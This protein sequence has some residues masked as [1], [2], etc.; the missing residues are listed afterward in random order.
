[1]DPCPARCQRDAPGRVVAAPLGAHP[2]L[3]RLLQ[4]TGDVMKTLSERGFDGAKN[5]AN[6]E[7]PPR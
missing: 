4:A 7:T 1:M 5:P 2:A 6:T 3:A